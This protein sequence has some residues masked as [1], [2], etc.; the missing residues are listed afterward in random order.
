MNYLET[1]KHKGNW[2]DNQDPLHRILCKPHVTSIIS[3][4]LGNGEE[5]VKLKNYKKGKHYSKKRTP[6]DSNRCLLLNTVA[7]V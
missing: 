5:S 3:N 1:F 4:F 6:L 7:Q 2:S